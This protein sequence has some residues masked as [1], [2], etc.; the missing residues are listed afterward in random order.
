MRW[1][2][3]LIWLLV[4]VAIAQSVWFYPKLPETM[5]SHFDGAGR[6]NRWSDKTGFFALYLVIV[7]FVASLFL[8]IGPLIRHR[9]DMRL[10]HREYWLSPERR[11]ETISFLRCRLLSA[12]AASL[13][14]AVV[15]A[16][17]AILANFEDPPRISDAIYWVLLAYFVYLGIWLLRLFTRFKKPPA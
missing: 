14:L 1:T 12:G 4:L 15:V 9:P 10:P 2:R 6:P 13:A 17:L 11:E 8:S 16:Q 7:A 5:A 3:N